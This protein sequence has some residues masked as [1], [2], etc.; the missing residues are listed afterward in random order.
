MGDLCDF[1]RGPVCITYA[2]DR[3]IARLVWPERQ[4]LAVRVVGEHRQRLPNGLRVPL[5]TASASLMTLLI[6]LDTLTHTIFG[7]V[8]DNEIQFI[9]SQPI[10]LR[11]NSIDGIDH[12]F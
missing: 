8:M 10:Q 6:V 3:Q 7:I 4:D 12:R 9:N 5:R 1:L 2:A 11:K